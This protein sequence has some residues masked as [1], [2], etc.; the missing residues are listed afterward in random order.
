MDTINGHLVVY[1]VDVSVMLSKAMKDQ[2]GKLFDAVS[3]NL[4]PQG[5]LGLPDNPPN[6][7]QNKHELDQ[8]PSL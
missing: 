5:M 6:N 2:S 1:P 4:E 7:C 8:L 3:T